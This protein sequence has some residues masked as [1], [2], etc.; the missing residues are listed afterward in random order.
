MMCA[1]HSGLVALE[2]ASV[3]PVCAAGGEDL[4]KL[5]CSHACSGWAWN[6]GSPA[7]AAGQE[8]EVALPCGGS[9]DDGAY[10]DSQQ[11]VACG[12]WV[13]HTRSQVPRGAKCA[14]EDYRG[15]GM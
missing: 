7:A 9:I 8:D 11:L 1:S 4:L 2:N 6:R 12:V 5:Q 10:K 3:D 13:P 14:I 15:C